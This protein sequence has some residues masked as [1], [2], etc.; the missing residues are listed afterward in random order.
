M[1]RIILVLVLA[2]AISFGLT[3]WIK[4]MAERLSLLKESNERSLHTGRVPRGGGLAIVVVWYLGVTLFY[5]FDIITPSLFYALL[6][7]LVLAGVSFL[8]DIIQVKPIIRLAVHF[9]VS[10][11]ALYL[12]GGL[13]K[14]VTPGIDILSI[15]EVINPLAVVGMVWFINLYNFMDGAD[16][17]ASVEAISIGL[18]LFVF[19]GSMELLLLVS[20][21]LGFLYW[22]WPKAKI[23]MG[24]VGSTQFGFILVVLGINYHNTLDFSIFN[25]LMIS[26]PFWFD[27][28]LTLFRRW[29]NKEK[30]SEAHR[31]H[32][33]QRFIRAGYSHKELD[34]ALIF[35]NSI[36]FLMI[37]IYR[38]FPFMKI[39][40]TIFTLGI[41][42]YLTRRVDRLFPFAKE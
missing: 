1:I 38:E 13:R 2:G 33:Y 17:F 4:R 23:F 24:D 21:V 11:A 20:A 26:S 27:A 19:T 7:G 35:F 39:P 37:L 42:Y 9:G 25:W 16:G 28:T 31:K 41:L 15:P 14:P 22:N 12:L 40:I 8:D 30:L 36:V 34:L 32:A 3:A 6:C 10:I 29:R 5:W 18:V